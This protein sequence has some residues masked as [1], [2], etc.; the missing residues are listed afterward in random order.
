MGGWAFKNENALQI[1]KF[2]Q[3]PLL[4]SVFF[5]F[6]IFETADGIEIKLTLRIRTLHFIK[7]CFK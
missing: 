6:K 5:L 2:V 4:P 7:Y 1:R 3:H